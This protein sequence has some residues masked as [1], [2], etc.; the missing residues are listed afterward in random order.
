MGFKKK[1]LFIEM[2]YKAC[3]LHFIFQHNQKI[4]F[5]SVLVMAAVA[6][7]KTPSLKHDSRKKGFI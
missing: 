5:L 6:V 3:K 2:F 1:G 4:M 7:I